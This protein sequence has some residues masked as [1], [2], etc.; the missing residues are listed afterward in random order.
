MACRGEKNVSIEWI[1]SEISDFT[2]SEQLTATYS[3]TET[4]LSWLELH[5]YKEGYY[6]CQIGNGS[7]FYIFVFDQSSTSKF[8]TFNLDSFEVFMLLFH[9]VVTI[10]NFE[11]NLQLVPFTAGSTVAMLYYSHNDI[12]ANIPDGEIH[13][14]TDVV[15][16]GEEWVYSTEYTNP[17]DL[18]TVFSNVGAGVHILSCFYRMS[19]VTLLGNI[20]VRIER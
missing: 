6:Q 7:S 11:D 8:I 2:T 20:T 3:S 9:F 14:T 15:V 17:A 18:N 10:H 12:Q 1:F 5:N 13:W 16:K 4:G 19:P